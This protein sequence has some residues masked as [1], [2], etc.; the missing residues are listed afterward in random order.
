MRPPVLVPAVLLL[1]VACAS[2][3][4]ADT[5]QAAV[6][7]KVRG[8][9]AGE[10]FDRYGRPLSRVERADGTLVFDW[11]GG[12]ERVAAGVYGPEEKICRLRITADRNGRITT[13]E[14]MRDGQG[15]RQLSR[16]VELLQR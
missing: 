15:E 5:S 14:I 7:A 11:S 12:S 16:C 3:N 10:F 1:L 8:M 4:E 9:S 2:R 6:N 13:A